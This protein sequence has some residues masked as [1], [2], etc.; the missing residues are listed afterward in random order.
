MAFPTLD[1]NLSDRTDL[2]APLGYQ[3]VQLVHL[4]KTLTTAMEAVNIVTAIARMPANTRYVD[5][6]AYAADLDSNGSPALTLNLGV[7]G[8]SDTTYD[9]ADAFLAASTIG[10]AGTGTDTILKAGM[11]LLVPVE[12][13]IT[14]QVAAGAATAVAGNLTVGIRCVLEST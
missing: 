7:A 9:D 8:V 6:Y 1:Y 14:V 12:H 3:A 4:S 2:P 10:Q 13:Y 5:L 11:G